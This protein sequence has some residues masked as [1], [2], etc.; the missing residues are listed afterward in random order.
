MRVALCERH[1]LGLCQIASPWHYSVS[2]IIFFPSSFSLSLTHLRPLPRLFFRL[3]P[4]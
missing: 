1:R 3:I 4:H 2:L